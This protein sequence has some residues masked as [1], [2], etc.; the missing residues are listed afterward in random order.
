MKPVSDLFSEE[1]KSEIKP[2][3]QYGVFM[4]NSDYVA[5]PCVIDALVSCFSFD[6]GQASK[7]AMAAHSNNEALIGSWNKDIAETKAYLAN[8]KLIDLHNQMNFEEPT[9]IFS[10]RLVD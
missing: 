7:I 8:Q 4:A 10:V 5:F 9:S 6:E 1:S 2:C 3:R